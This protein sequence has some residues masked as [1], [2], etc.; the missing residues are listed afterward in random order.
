MKLIK[1]HS[2]QIVIEVGDNGS[3]KI[4]S[5]FVREPFFNDH[6]NLQLDIIESMLLAAAAEGLI[7][8]I[9]KWDNVIETV[10]DGISN[11][12]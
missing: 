12:T 1:L 3:A 2:D 5:G 11:N 10:M 6:D 8:D 9:Q 4:A 7:T